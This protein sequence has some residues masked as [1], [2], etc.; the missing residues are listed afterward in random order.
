VRTVP[1]QS[2]YSDREFAAKYAIC[3][4]ESR[5]ARFWLRVAN[6]KSLGNTARRKY[7]LEQSNE[8]IAIYATIVRKL[9]GK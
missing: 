2:S 7:L 4:K 5:E 6:A 3:L 1:S 9:K 8:L